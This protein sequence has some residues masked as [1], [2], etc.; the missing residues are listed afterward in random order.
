LHYLGEPASRCNPSK[1]ETW[2]EPPRRPPAFA[3]ETK[4]SS[5]LATFLPSSHLRILD[6]L[7]VETGEQL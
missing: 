3:L 7:E 5:E 1:L 6:L 4:L 2:R